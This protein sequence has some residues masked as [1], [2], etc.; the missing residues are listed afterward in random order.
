MLDPKIFPCPILSLP[1]ER[2]RGKAE[3]RAGNNQVHES[4]VIPINMA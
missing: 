4:L 1:Q 2:G 3:K